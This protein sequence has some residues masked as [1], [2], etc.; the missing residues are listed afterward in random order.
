VGVS[1][2]H[3]SRLVVITGGPFSGKTTLVSELDDLGFPTIPEAAIDVI[4]RLNRER[5]VARQQQWRSTHVVEFQQ[6]IF[7][8]QV[9][10]EEA[11]AP[12]PGPAFLDRGIG[13]GIAYCLHYGLDPPPRFRERALASG[14]E[15][16]FVLETLEGFETRPSTGRMS[17]RQDSLRI[18]GI[19]A[20]V[21]DSLGVDVTWLESAP[22]EDRVSTV[23]E[24]V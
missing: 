21:Y 3:A 17:H 18:A 14:Y 8:L 9:G 16:A 15:H 10:R 2:A 19:I 13:D 22:L 11:L 24:R 23:L 6:M 4:E 5:G 20:E 12:G 1:A 7:D